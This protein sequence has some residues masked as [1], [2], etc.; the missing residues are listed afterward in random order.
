MLKKLTL[1]LVGTIIGGGAVLAANGLFSDVPSDAWYADAVERLNK[2]GILKGYED[3]T[4][5]PGDNVSR[6][7]MAVMLDRVMERLDQTEPMVSAANNTEDNVGESN[8][9]C[10]K[11]AV[12]NEIG[13][14]EYPI[15]EKYGNLYYLGQFFTAAQ[16]GEARMNELYYVD[17]SKY[18]SGATVWLKDVPSE[19]LLSALREIGFEC[20]EDTIQ[21][22]C[23]KWKL[24]NEVSTD[25]MIK[26]ETYH[27]EI[28]ADDCYICG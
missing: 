6:A 4:F 24:T 18:T 3:G 7:E 17:K 16:C 5:R 8:H 13:F 9:L 2:K 14:E 23:V 11:K 25:E 19:G 12:S 28:S 1:V 27:R 10:M 20:D 15:D 22:Q 26:L 21:R